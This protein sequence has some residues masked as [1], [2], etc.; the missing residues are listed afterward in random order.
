MKVFLI[1]GT[2]A[3]VLWFAWATRELRRVRRQRKG[4]R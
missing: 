1:L 2:L 4:Q 3:S